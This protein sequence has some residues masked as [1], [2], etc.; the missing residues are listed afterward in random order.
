M[1]QRQRRRRGSLSRQVASWKRIKLKFIRIGFG[2]CLHFDV[3]ISVVEAQR[4]GERGTGSSSKCIKCLHMHIRVC[5]F[6][7]VCVFV[8]RPMNS[9]CFEYK[10]QNQSVYCPRKVKPKNHKPSSSKLMAIAVRSLQLAVEFNFWAGR[11]PSRYL[12]IYQ[13]GASFIVFS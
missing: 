3:L 7:C 6:V 11:I 1:R 12:S 9:R 13:A 5:A 8:F 4:N 2:E 10:Q